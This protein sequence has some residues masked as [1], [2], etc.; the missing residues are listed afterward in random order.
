M[1]I[2]K[3]SAICL[4]G[5]TV[6]F[7]QQPAPP[8]APTPAT[9][10]VVAPAPPPPPPQQVVAPAPA[11]APM[12]FTAPVSEP[13]V[14]TEAPSSS[15]EVAAYLPVSSSSAAVAVP[16]GK[17]IFDAVRGNAFN[18]YGT[19]GAASTVRDLAEKPA[20][21]YG[22]KFFYISP[23]TSVGY[24]ALPLG[25]G[26]VLIGLDKTPLPSSNLASWV[27]GYAN[28]SFG[29]SL[30]YSVSK[31]WQSADKY[32][33]RTTGAGD[34]IGIY[35][36]TTGGLYANANWLTY[37]TSTSVDY[38]GDTS[39]EDYSQI[40]GNVGLTGKSGSLDYDGYLN[41]IR[42]GGTRKLP[43]GD[44]YIDGNTFLGLAVNL[45]L[46]YTA[47]QSANARVI[48]GS[49]NRI[50]AISIDNVKDGFKG[51]N[52]MGVVISPNILG[53]FALTE[54]WLTFAGASNAINVI[55]G[56]GDGDSK[57]SGFAVAHSNN[58][59]GAYVGL[60]YQKANLALEATVEA[61]VFNNP[62][63][64]FAG[65]SMFAGFGGFVYF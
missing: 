17:T 53:E 59:S 58:G 12:Q 50:V 52:I 28:S 61:N 30:D 56:D 8:K 49:N 3:L 55:I 10:Q 27:L 1:N 19:V 63:G 65:S 44:K 14:L 25:D 29:L 11:P 32:S 57:T 37:G 34:N 47:F 41:V 18:P 15:S 13:A 35:F 40:E 31:A 51:D 54:N 42:T 4:L 38:D 6:A 9:P 21:I 7:A 24:T 45:D 26:S 48:F 20:E 39:V 62:A 33:T 43:N 60:R 5:A 36:S 64:G 2:F 22:N 46:G 23:V 16:E